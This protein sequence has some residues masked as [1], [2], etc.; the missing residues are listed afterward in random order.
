MCNVQCAMCNVQCAMCNVQCTMCNVQCAMYNVKYYVRAR[1]TYLVSCTFV[2]CAATVS[3]S[4]QCTICNVHWDMCRLQ[5]SSVQ[6]WCLW[7][8]SWQDQ[9]YLQQWRIFMCSAVQCS[10]KSSAKV[11]IGQSP[12]F[13]KLCC[14]VLHIWHTHCR[15]SIHWASTTFGCNP[16]C[17]LINVH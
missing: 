15:Q 2:C 4:V 14:R 5:F 13:S 9:S 16:H 6:P 11:A 1:R 12:L 8:Y 3:C 7:P 10:V 17:P